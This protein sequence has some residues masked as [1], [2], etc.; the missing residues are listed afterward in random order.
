MAKIEYPSP[1]RLTNEEKEGGRDLSYRV[2]STT[3]RKQLDALHFAGLECNLSR[4]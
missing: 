1:D 4:S 3:P 2:I